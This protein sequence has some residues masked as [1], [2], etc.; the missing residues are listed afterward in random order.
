MGLLQSCQ[1]LQQLFCYQ[2][3]MQNSG[4]VFVFTMPQ[5]AVNVWPCRH[6][7]YPETRQL[8]CEA[9]GGVNASPE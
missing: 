6:S 4:A 9:F 3:L 1:V 8:A 5:Q 2:N 7:C